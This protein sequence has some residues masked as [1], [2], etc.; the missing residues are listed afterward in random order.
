YTIIDNDG[1]DA[2]T[3]TISGLAEGATITAGGN[4]TV[5]SASYTGG[6]GND[7]TLTAPTFPSVTGVTSSSG[8]GLYGIDD[9]ITITVTFDANVLVTGTPQLLL[10]TGTADRTLN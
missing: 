3:G 2:V 6:T 5:L 1:A 4:G 8:N 9:V 7:F 10:E